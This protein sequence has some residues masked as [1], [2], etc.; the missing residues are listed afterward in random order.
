MEIKLQALKIENYKGIKNLDL[1]PVGKSIIITGKNGTGKTTIADAW[2]WLLTGSNL[3]NQSKYNIL[4]LDDGAVP[5]DHQNAN[6]TAVISIDDQEIE[7]KKIYRQK[8]TKKRGQAELEFTGH[9]TDHFWNGV[10]VSAKEYQRRLDEI[11]QDSII[12]TLSDVYHFCGRMR[13]DDRRQELISIA[14]DISIESICSQFD[15]LADLPEIIGD[16]SIEDVTKILKSRKK[17]AQ[18]SLNNIPIEINAKKEELPDISGLEKDE[19]NGNIQWFEKKITEKNTEISELEHGLSAVALKKEMAEI[20]GL[21]TEKSRIIESQWIEKRESLITGKYDSQQKTRTLKMKLDDAKR[22]ITLSDSTISSRMKSKSKLLEQYKAAKNGSHIC[23]CCGQP[24]PQDQI[25][26][27]IA[28]INNEGRKLSNE[29]TKLEAEKSALIEKVGNLEMWITTEAAT[30]S[31]IDH[32]ISEIEKLMVIQIEHETSSLREK[33]TRLK[34]DLEKDGDGHGEQISILKNAIDDLQN[35]AGR[36][37]SKL[38]ILEQWTKSMD[39]IAIKEKMLAE[40]AVEFESVERSLYLLEL[41]SR[42]RGEFIEENVSQNFELTHWKLFE[43]QINQGSRE[44]CEAVYQGV[45]YS[46]DLNTGA[47]IQVGLDVIKTLS[48]HHQ[49]TMPVFVDN[50]ESVTEWLVDLN[51]QIIRLQ[52]AANIEKLETEVVNV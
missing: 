39:R 51:N 31:V 49:I 9:T 14:G 4:E 26:A 45:P 11:C 23:H 20:E 28:S 44:I 12:R 5:I 13:P 36:E 22:K 52:A 3:D 17:A 50:S 15:D 7:L 6:V 41:Y 19:I 27:N 1:E 46:T 24:L 30:E 35:E 40:A 16:K 34:I 18:K 43:D 10:D 2:F 8:W 48:R 32:E 29:I 33:V 37:R 38:L 25:D 42:K 21:I 47:K